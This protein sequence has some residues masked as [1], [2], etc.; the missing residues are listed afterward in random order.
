LRP[1]YTCLKCEGFVCWAEQEG[2]GNSKGSHER[3]SMNR[4]RQRVVGGPQY[5]ITIDLNDIIQS[6]EEV[7]CVKREIVEMRSEIRSLLGK[8][9]EELRCWL[10]C[11]L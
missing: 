3:R 11:V 9:Y 1:Y 7:S 2:R 6:K 4:G 5:S 8:I 10:Y